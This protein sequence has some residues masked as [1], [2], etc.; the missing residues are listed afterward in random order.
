MIEWRLIRSEYAGVGMRYPL[1]LNGAI[2]GWRRTDWKDKTAEREKRATIFV[3][4]YQCPYMS[5]SIEESRPDPFQLSCQRRQENNIFDG[6]Q[7]RTFTEPVSLICWSPNCVCLCL[8][9]QI[10]C[11]YRPLSTLLL[12]GLV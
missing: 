4:W 9:H 11:W 2:H 3:Y 8:L 6:F 12:K 5:V 1:V 10:V 7:K